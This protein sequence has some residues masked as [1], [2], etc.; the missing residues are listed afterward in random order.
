MDATTWSSRRRP[1]PCLLS[2]CSSCSRAHSYSQLWVTD[3]GPVGSHC[4]LFLPCLF[5]EAPALCLS[6][7][8]CLCCTEL[9]RVFQRGVWCH[10][11]ISLQ[12]MSLFSSDNWGAEIQ[13]FKWKG[14]STSCLFDQLIDVRSRSGSISVDP[15]LYSCFALRWCWLP[16]TRCVAL[17][18]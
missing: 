14:L 6:S 3:T 8:C 1:Q 2:R 16:W 12:A 11:C 17:L 4:S 5:M 15:V 13:G 7:G 10:L 18:D 9:G